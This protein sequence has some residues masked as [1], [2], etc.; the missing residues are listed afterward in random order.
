MLCMQVLMTEMPRLATI[1][2]QGKLVQPWVKDLVEAWRV[3]SRT[4]P[5]G[6]HICIDLSAIFFADESGRAAL[7]FLHQAGCK[8]L[9]SEDFITEVL[10]VGSIPP[11][12]PLLPEA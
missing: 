7:R 5:V 1:R 12:E 6:S 9:G 10:G 11:R 3:Q 8:L 4:L 2:L